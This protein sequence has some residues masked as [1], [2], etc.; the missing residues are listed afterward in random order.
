[1]DS[2]H[3]VSLADHQRA[4]LA[5]RSRSARAHPAP[6]PRYSRQH[7][8]YH[9]ASRH[10]ADCVHRS[11]AAELVDNA[12]PLPEAGGYVHRAR[13]TVLQGAVEYCCSV[14]STGG[15]SKSVTRR[16]VSILNG[17]TPAQLEVHAI[18]ICHVL[19]RRSS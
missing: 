15:D 1:S 10:P 6:C 12:H 9:G 7:Q 4:L 19:R 18:T 13:R 2:R 3:P 14:K 8:E 16:P 17:E 5:L 11:R